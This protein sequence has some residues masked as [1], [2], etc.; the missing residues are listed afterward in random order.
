MRAV[1]LHELYPDAEGVPDSELIPLV[2]KTCPSDD[3]FRER[4]MTIRAAGITRFWTMEHSLK[5][6]SNPGRRSKTHVA[7]QSLKDRTGRRGQRFATPS[8][9]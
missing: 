4:P 8:G 9:S 6:P 5:D 2:E 7:S 3:P 1:F